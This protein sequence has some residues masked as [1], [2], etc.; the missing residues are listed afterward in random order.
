MDLIRF[1]LLL[2]AVAIIP[3]SMHV[4]LDMAKIAYSTFIEN[5]NSGMPGCTARNSYPPEELGRIE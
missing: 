1:P 2:V 3:I 4:N 5:G